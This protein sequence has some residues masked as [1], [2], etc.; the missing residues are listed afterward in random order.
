M[1]KSGW[2][3]QKKKKKMH[4]HEKG[5]RTKKKK[6]REKDACP[7]TKVNGHQKKQKKQKKN[8]RCKSMNKVD[9]P[10]KKKIDDEVTLSHVGKSTT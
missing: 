7:W 9:G 4:V 3:P 8:W 10:K 2:T 6:K 1:N 5:G